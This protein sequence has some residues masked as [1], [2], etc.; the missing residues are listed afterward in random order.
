M[1][2]PQHRCG[3]RC[4]PDGVDCLVNRLLPLPE[5][6]VEEVT[7][8]GRVAGQSRGADAEE[9]YRQQILRQTVVENRLDRLPDRIGQVRGL[10]QGLGTVPS[11]EVEARIFS[12][13]VRARSPA[14]HS[15]PASWMGN[16]QFECPERCSARIA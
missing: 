13:T 15:Q 7:L 11:P 2:S 12:S 16:P 5:A 6:T 3:S 4:P 10:R 1:S 8:D 14:W 9:P